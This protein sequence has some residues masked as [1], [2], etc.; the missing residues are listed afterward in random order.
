MR[1][2]DDAIVIII[3]VIIIQWA[4]ASRSRSFGDSDNWSTAVVFVVFVI[5]FGFFVIDK[6]S[7]WR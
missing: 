1:C 2:E 6:N 4:V 7:R 3:V 5:F